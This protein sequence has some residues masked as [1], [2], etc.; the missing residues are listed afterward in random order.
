MDN[1]QLRKTVIDDL[2]LLFEFQLDEEANHLAAFTPNNF[3]DKEAYLSKHT[4]LLNDPKIN[5][6]TIL[7]N[8]N[9]VGSIAKFEMFGDNEITYWIERKYWG[10]GIATTA[11]KLFLTIERS[12][13]LFGRIAFD[14]IGSQRVLEKCGFIKFG[15][16]KGFANARK[17]EIEESIYKLSL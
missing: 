13:P 9:I 7:F 17:S 10:K 8:N 5:N 3:K 11:L 12:R 14:N 15:S 1:V 4:K 16:A 2:P 6:Q